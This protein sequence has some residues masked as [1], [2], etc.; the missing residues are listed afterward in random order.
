VA[1]VLSLRKQA[2][3]RLPLQRTF[4]FREEL[5]DLF[6]SLALPLGGVELGLGP[7]FGVA[8]TLALDGLVV[9][10]V[11]GAAW[12]PENRL[13][14]ALVARGLVVDWLVEVRGIHGKV[15]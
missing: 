8:L 14:A 11:C 3:P 10:D 13:G 4:P 7:T 2:T 9:V 12:A 5:K 6:L 1:F 15:L